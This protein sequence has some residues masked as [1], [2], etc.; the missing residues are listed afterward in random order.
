MFSSTQHNGVKRK[1]VNNHFLVSPAQ[2]GLTPKVMCP[3]ISQCASM[4]A[5]V[6][7]SVCASVCK[8]K[9]LLAGA[10]I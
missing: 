2:G 5:S 6:Y 9:N 10:S 1:V 3:Q 4:S 8:L 7:A